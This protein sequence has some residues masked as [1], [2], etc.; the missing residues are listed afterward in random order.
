MNILLATKGLL[1]IGVIL[2]G[3]T[4]GAYFGTRATI[5]EHFSKK[6]SSNL[7]KVEKNGW[8]AAFNKLK[9]TPPETTPSSPSSPEFLGL[10]EP[11]IK[12]KGDLESLCEGFYTSTYKSFGI[13]HIKTE[14]KLF[15][16]IEAYCFV[17][18]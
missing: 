3:S 6:V 12:T 9:G 5:E 13:E 18:G 10:K 4:A 1:G 11:P 14:S 7:K 17:Q 2:G 16:D 8:E 15:K